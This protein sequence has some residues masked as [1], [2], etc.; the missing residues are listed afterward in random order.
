MGK[1]YQNIDYDNDA[2]RKGR[3]NMIY[4]APYFSVLFLIR[5]VDDEV[6]NHERRGYNH[7]SSVGNAEKNESN[8]YLPPLSFYHHVY[9]I[10]SKED[11]PYIGS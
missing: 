8:G 6:A 9:G 11:N 2:S 4:D 3:N 7:T 1:T 5:N 10:E